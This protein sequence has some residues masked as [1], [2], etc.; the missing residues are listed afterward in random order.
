MLHFNLHTTTDPKFVAEFL[1]NSI[2]TQLDFGKKVLWFA[3]G[4]SSISD[5]ARLILC[6]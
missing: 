4:G 1:A 6:I 2:M 5:S 3:T